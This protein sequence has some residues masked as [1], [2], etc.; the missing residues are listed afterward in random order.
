MLNANSKFIPSLSHLVTTN[1]FSMSVGLF[2]FCIQVHLYN[3][4]ESL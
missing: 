2:L 3:F 4:F 1:L